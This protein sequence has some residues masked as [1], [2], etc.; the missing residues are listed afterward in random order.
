M[1]P[2]IVLAAGSS[3][4]MGRPKALLTIGP[5]RETF[6]DR[7]TRTLAEGGIDETIVVLGVDAA[8]VQAGI[9]PPPRTRFVVNPAPE[10]GQL[11]SLLEGL[12]VVDR[13]G[14]RAVLVTLVDIPLVAAE[15]VRALV[16]AYGTGHALITRPAKD[17]RH[18]H[19]VIFDRAVFG[20]LRRADPAVGVKVVLA[21]RASDVQN[22]P[23]EDEGAFLDVDTPLEYEKIAWILERSYR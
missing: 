8:V 10:R 12:R 1:I 18:G 13:P 7:I 9:A 6:L 23:C 4:R 11:S 14:V 20:D 2:A 17:G 21:T 15:T 5:S 16:E 3:T 22:V 19:P